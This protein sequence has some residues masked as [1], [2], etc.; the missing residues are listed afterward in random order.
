M[1]QFGNLAQKQ[2]F[3]VIDF[4]EG[5]GHTLSVSPNIA[6]CWSQS[7]VPVELPKRCSARSS[8]E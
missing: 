8:T 5:P 4:S 3:A 2:I 7:A 6:E 1:V